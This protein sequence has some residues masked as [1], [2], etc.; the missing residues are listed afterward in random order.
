MA[1]INHQ[2]GG[3]GDGL[4]CTGEGI[5]LQ[6]TLKQCRAPHKNYQKYPNGRTSQ[7]RW[8]VTSVNKFQ[9]LT[10]TT[11]FYKIH[12]ILENLKGCTF[13]FFLFLAQLT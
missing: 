4:L 11:K 13:D 12:A 8:G 2:S 1:R 7:M 5:P 6:V 10:P 9:A 3:D